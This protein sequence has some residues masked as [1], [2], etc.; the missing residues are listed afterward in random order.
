MPA[1]LIIDDQA[2]ILQVFS[3]ALE[4]S[5]H[6]VQIAATA[7]VALKLVET[8]PPDAILL[9]LTMPYINGMGFL[10]RLRKVHPR[11]PV[12][13]ITGASSLDDAADSGNRHARRVAALQAGE[14]R[15]TSGDRGRAY[16]DSVTWNWPLL[17]VTTSSLMPR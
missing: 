16:Q 7:E 8:D 10:Y 14:R 1:I 4:M 3:R 11:I 13:I 15:R 6:R 9:D 5:G 2:E 12:A 17:S